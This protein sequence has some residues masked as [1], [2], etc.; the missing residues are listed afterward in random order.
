MTYLTL[1]SPGEG[2]DRCLEAGPAEAS[3]SRPCRGPRYPNWGQPAQHTVPK[4]RPIYGPAMARPRQ[5]NGLALVE[6]W[7][8]HGQD[9]L[10]QSNG[11]V[12]IETR[13]PKTRSE[14]R[15]SEYGADFRSHVA[16][17]PLRL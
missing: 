11:L 2:T 5:G 16:V 4:S 10:P 7:S 13:C 8:S 1:V 12:I 17:P 3:G 15:G 9:L 6:R 14:E